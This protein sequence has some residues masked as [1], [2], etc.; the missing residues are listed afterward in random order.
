M[1]AFLD[2]ALGLPDGPNAFADD[3][4]SIFEANINALAAA[5]IT[6]GL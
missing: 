1:A 3:D 2:R 6:E 5:G 4:Q